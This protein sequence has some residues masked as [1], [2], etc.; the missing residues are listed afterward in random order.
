MIV[1]LRGN[2]ASDPLL[3][4]EQIFRDYAAGVYNRARRLLGS[5]SDAD[6]VTQDVFLQVLRKLLSFRGEAAFPTW[7]Y[8]VT[9]NAAL[10]Y[11]RKRA[12]RREHSVSKLRE[13]SIAIGNHHSPV[14]RRLAGPEKLALD[15]ETNQLIQEAI[16]RLPEIYRNL[17]VL[18][19]VEELSNRK[20]AGML[21]LSVAAVKSRLHRARLMMRKA[22]APHLEEQAA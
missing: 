9:V 13:E 12:T 16:A 10:S 15:Q 19:D 22:L 17:Y 5:D 14:E 1:P 7:L 21:G 11:R 4:P 2:H 8:R 18:A 3:T 6:D 20:I